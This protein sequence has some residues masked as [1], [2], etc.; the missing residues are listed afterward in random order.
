MFN[1]EI[2][3]CQ[4]EHASNRTASCVARVN[5]HG[6]PAALAPTQMLTYTRADIMTRDLQ[7]LLLTKGRYRK[8]RSLRVLVQEATTEPHARW[9]LCRHTDV[10]TCRK[11]RLYTALVRLAPVSLS[12]G[13][14]ASSTWPYLPNKEW[15]SSTCTHK[16]NG[17]VIHAASTATSATQLAR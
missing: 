13:M 2:W 7:K 8:K 6:M 9:N 12:L 3:C 10:I 1:Q 16:G 4:R 5:A 11:K 17:S 15:R 14:N